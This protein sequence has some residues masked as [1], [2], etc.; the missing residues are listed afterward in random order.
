MGTA[1]IAPSRNADQH[2]EAVYEA[3]C[4]SC[5]QHS[6]F[7]YGGEQRWPTRVAHAAGIPIV[8]SL[9]HCGMC[10]STVTETSIID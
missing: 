10:H 3:R 2:S 1:G 4:P 5:G 7:T 9:W 6:T 8:V